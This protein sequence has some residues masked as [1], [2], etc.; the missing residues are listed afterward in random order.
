[1][2]TDVRRDRGERGVYACTR[3][4]S[5][6]HCTVYIQQ[7]YSIYSSNIVVVELVVVGASSPSLCARRRVQRVHARTHARTRT[8]RWREGP[9][10]N[11]WGTLMT[12]TTSD[13][14]RCTPSP[15]RV[16]GSGGAV[17]WWGFA[18]R[19]HSSGGRAKNGR[20]YEHPS[21]RRSRRPRSPRTADTT[22][23]CAHRRRCCT[24][25][26][27]QRNATWRAHAHGWEMQH[28]ESGGVLSH[29]LLAHTHR[30]D[31]YDR[32]HYYNIIIIMVYDYAYA[33]TRFSFE[34]Q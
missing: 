10:G 13:D 25:A 18:C 19:R 1:M 22:V 3:A 28:R 11:E 29:T 15:G 21:R 32:A 8:R 17:Q 27:T 9:F 14:D 7:Y 31:D 6:R 33:V 20:R 12:T 30:T 16:L 24:H 34:T 5:R 26:H 4:A 2:I 23:R